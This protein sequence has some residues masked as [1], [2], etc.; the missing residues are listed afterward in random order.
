MAAGDHV[1]V[2]MLNLTDLQMFPYTHLSV[3]NMKK[4]IS[5]YENLILKKI[6]R[7][8]YKPVFLNYMFDSLAYCF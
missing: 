2:I 7:K 1:A 3:L 4:I 6:A 8:K 5:F